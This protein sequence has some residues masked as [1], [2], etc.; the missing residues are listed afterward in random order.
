ML[1]NTK[2]LEIWVMEIMNIY[3]FLH[4]LSLIKIRPNMDF[5]GNLAFAHRCHK[6]HSIFFQGE[7][8]KNY[9]DKPTKHVRTHHGFHSFVC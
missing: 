5:G 3:D 4:L 9:V 2:V 1:F 6:T 8:G 7:W